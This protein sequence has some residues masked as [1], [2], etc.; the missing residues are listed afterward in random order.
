M[1][2]LPCY[3]AGK[4]VTSS[5]TLAVK[6]PYDGSTVGDSGLSGITIFIDANSNGSLDGGELSTVTALPRRILF[7]TVAA[8]ASTI[9]GT[10]TA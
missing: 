9:S 3:V 2:T 6:N 1:L 4:P 10:D 7:V 5:Q 8:A